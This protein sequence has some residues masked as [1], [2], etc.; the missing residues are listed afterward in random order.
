MNDEKVIEYL[1]ETENKLQELMQHRVI[2]SDYSIIEY[3]KVQ[4]K[5]LR[6]RNNYYKK[7]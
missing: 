3:I 5:D 1:T 7:G 2:K 6:N 4:I